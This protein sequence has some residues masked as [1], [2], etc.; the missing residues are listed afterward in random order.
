MQCGAPG[1]MTDQHID[2]SPITFS[3]GRN[4]RAFNE[5]VTQEQITS[6]LE[7]LQWWFGAGRVEGRSVVDVGCGSGL[8]SLAFHLLGAGRIVSFDRDPDWIQ[9]SRHHFA[10]PG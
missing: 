8:S 10:P 7:D 2:A 6:A 4:W 5:T 9:A 3:F 1:P